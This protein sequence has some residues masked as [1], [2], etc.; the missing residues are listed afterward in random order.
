MRGEGGI[1]SK[2]GMQPKV[3]DRRIRY[4]PPRKPQPPDQAEALTLDD[5]TPLREVWATVRDELTQHQA[6][7]LRERS[8]GYTPDDV[9][10]IFG[11]TPDAVRKLE[12]RALRRIED[13]RR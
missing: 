2:P 4:A 6:D 3:G 12:T 7:V 1:L 13:A 5:G 9:A 8:K 10:I 11:I